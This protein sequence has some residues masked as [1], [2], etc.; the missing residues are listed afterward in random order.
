MAT[1]IALNPSK[2][3]KK[4]KKPAKKKPAAN[5][6]P[7]ALKKHTRGKSMAKGKKKKSKRR[8][9]SVKSRAK[10]LARRGGSYAKSTIAG[11]N[12][13][14]AVKNT[15]PQ[16]LGAVATKFAAKKFADGGAESD[17][18]TWKNYAFGALGGFVAA[19]IM[20]AALKKRGAAQKV[21]EGSL[22]LL[23]YKIFTNEI[24]PKNDTLEEWFGEADEDFDPYDGVGDPG[25]IWTGSEIDYVKGADGAWRPAGEA[26]RL[27]QGQQ[28]GMG[29]VLVTPDPR[30]GDVLVDTNPYY[31]NT[32]SP[33]TTAQAIASDGM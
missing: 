22:L 6:K 2:K 19:F 5:K 1:I 14:A 29:D 9:P 28:R 32:P 20:S 25:D 26:H 27:P 10:S 15:F 31:G 7:A 24:A 33:L 17:N 11:I 16:L 21:F 13:T 23:G 8:N 18:W 4:K 30:F 12:M 3:G